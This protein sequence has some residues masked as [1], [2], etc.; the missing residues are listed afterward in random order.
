MR[1]NGENSSAVAIWAR[2]WY[3]E[4]GKGLF[5]GWKGE[6]MEKLNFKN[7]MIL[8]VVILLGLMTRFGV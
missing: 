5:S 4:S 8:G 2:T 3:K 7:Q 1:Q 6:K